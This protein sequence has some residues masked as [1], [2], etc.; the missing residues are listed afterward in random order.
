MEEK[1]TV[2]QVVE[3]TPK[4][5]SQDTE[6]EILEEKPAEAPKKKKSATWKYILNIFLVLTITALSIFF[7]VRKNFQLII[8]YIITSDYRFI[9]AIIGLMLSYV[10][11]KGF[12]FFC[13][14]RLFTRKYK[15]HQGIA[16]EYIGT[17]YAAVTPGGQG[18][19]V[20][21]AYTYAKQ[22]IPI[23]SAVSA[24]AMHSIIHQVILILFGIVSFI[25]K[26]D[27]IATLP[28]ANLGTYGDVTIRV[29]MWVLTIFGFGLNV[30]Y[31]L[32]IFMMAYWKGFHNFMMGPIVSFLGKIRILKN[33]DKSRENF[34]TQ[35]ENF[36]IE[37]RRLFSNIPFT[38]LVSLVF[39]VSMSIKF[40]I[41]YFVGLAMGNES[42]CASFFDAV[43][44]SN[45]HQMATGLIPVPG[46]A[47]VSEFVFNTLYSTSPAL[48]TTSFFYLHANADQVSSAYTTIL[49]DPTA[50]HDFFRSILKYVNIKAFPDSGFA[51]VYEIASEASKYK[52]AATELA[53]TSEAFQKVVQMYAD[54]QASSS[55][56]SAALV[57]WRVATF[58]FPLTVAGFVTAF[59]RASPKKEAENSEN[60]AGRQTFVDLQ[61]ETYSD[62]AALVETMVET[63]RLT[64]ES[65]AKRLRALAK[66]DRKRKAK[67]KADKEAEKNNIAD[68]DEFT[69][70]TINDGDDSL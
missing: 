43:F 69:D 2:E 19:E 39:I 11:I 62:R 58:I 20:M 3:E 8:H 46:S 70:V 44:L 32:L 54:T 31:I 33:P 5:T 52:D 10:V 42:T 28:Y 24:L 47:G 64:R 53:D 36:K 49:K 45:Y 37:T 41:P 1:E 13:F 61:R 55:M 29:P 40:S 7:A 34:R 66:L 27:F 9:L 56:A 23:S 67:A 4:D 16:V 6:E 26:Y 22:G 25:V 12:M 14:A 30:G 17:F 50:Y 18:G 51:N 59:Y 57:M 35:I 68:P 48:P 15:L 63:S 60:L 65:I 21:Q 38:L